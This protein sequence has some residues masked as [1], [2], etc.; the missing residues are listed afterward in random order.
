[1]NPYEMMDQAIGL[2]L[3][4]LG[5]LRD[6]AAAL[7][8]LARRRPVDS[9]GSGSQNGT[10]SNPYDTVAEGVGLAWDGCRVII[11]SGSYSETMTITEEITLLASGG[12]VVIGS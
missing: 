7:S 3:I 1:M 6:A 8:R 10:Q 4:L 11:D 9:S 2:P 5:I 12:S